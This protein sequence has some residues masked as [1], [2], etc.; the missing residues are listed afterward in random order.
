MIQNANVFRGIR[1]GLWPPC[2]TGTPSGGSTIQRS[3]DADLQRA[4]G[5]ATFICGDITR[6]EDVDRALA[7]GNGR[8][9]RFVDIG[10]FS[11]LTIGGGTLNCAILRSGQPAASA[12]R[13]ANATRAEFRPG[14]RRRF[15][16]KSRSETWEGAGYV[17]VPEDFGAPDPTSS[18][19]R[20]IG[21]S[22]RVCILRPSALTFGTAEPGPRAVQ[23]FPK[24]E[25]LLTH[26]RAAF[27]T[28]SSG[29]RV[30]T[31]WVESDY[32]AYFHRL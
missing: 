22:L 6:A 24:T 28:G 17:P 20:S 30:G 15:V 13:T 26:A 16:I 2:N 29:K 23:R 27:K 1:G 14:P 32:G 12:E 31:F 9:L 21:S 5:H 3:R 18:D 11:A 8:L 7:A 10:D 19:L 4:R 25:K